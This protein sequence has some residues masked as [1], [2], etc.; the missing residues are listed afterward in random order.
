MRNLRTQ[1]EAAGYSW[2][3]FVSTFQD[4][5]LEMISTGSVSSFDSMIAEEFPLVTG[6]STA[7]TQD[8]TNANSLGG[9]DFT[10]IP[11][12]TLLQWNG[13]SLVAVNGYYQICYW[14]EENAALTN[15]NNEW[16]K[17]GDQE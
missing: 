9:I 2:N 10:S 17:R 5:I 3:E 11:S 7:I 12:G 8:E 6:V 1:V 13:T 14:S 15:N 16:R 4:E